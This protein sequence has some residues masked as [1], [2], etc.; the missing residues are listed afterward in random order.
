MKKQAKQAA[1]TDRLLGSS[2]LVSHAWLAQSV[3]V[4]GQ[5]GKLVVLAG[6]Q[7]LDRELGVEAAHFSSV[8]PGGARSVFLDLD[9]V[10]CD[11]STA[12]IG[13][14]HPFQGDAVFCRFADG[15]FVGWP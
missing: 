7:V 10:A 15:D 5:H 12:V 2:R 13:R 8:P 1:L 6:S 14:W 11:A 3:L 9:M 4:L